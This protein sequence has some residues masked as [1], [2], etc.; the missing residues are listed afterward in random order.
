MNS[1]L[2]DIWEELNHRMKNGFLGIKDC[3]DLIANYNGDDYLKG[4]HI[5]P[6]KYNRYI[7]YKNRE[8]EI[9]IVTWA[10]NQQSGFHGHPGECIF[11]VLEGVILEELKPVGSVENQISIFNAGDCGYINNSIGQ[12]Y[13]Y[14]QNGAVS[15]HIYSPPFSLNNTKNNIE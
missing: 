7:V 5:N 15:L 9:V 3:Q 14:S 11:R 8:I 4:V 1:S 12:H 6:D 10:S 13:M 2:S